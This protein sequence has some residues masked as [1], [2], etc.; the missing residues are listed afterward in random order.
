MFSF[1]ASHAHARSGRKK[2]FVSFCT[3]PSIKSPMSPLQRC[4]SLQ[5]QDY[6]QALINSSNEMFL[7]A[8]VFSL[9]P[10]W[11]KTVSRA[12]AIHRDKPKRTVKCKDDELLGLS[13]VGNTCEHPQFRDRCELRVG[14]QRSHANY[15]AEFCCE[16]TL[17]S[18]IDGESNTFL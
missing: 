8:A 4:M 14:M 5:P 1:S 9:R 2:R 17:I 18:M 12:A 13:N 7:S 16:R 6:G 15:A 3:H 10:A 11:N